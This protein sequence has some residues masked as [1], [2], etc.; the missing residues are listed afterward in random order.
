MLT[1]SPFHQIYPRVSI[2]H[3]A[4]PPHLDLPRQRFLDWDCHLL[5]CF[6]L[7]ILLPESLPS[8]LIFSQENNLALVRVLDS[9][10]RSPLYLHKDILNTLMREK[11]AVLRTLPILHLFQTTHGPFTLFQLLIKDRV[12]AAFAHVPT[13]SIVAVIFLVHAYPLKLL[14]AG[15]N[16]RNETF[17]LV[18]LLLLFHGRKSRE[19]HLSSSHLCIFG[20]GEHTLHPAGH[21]AN[22]LVL[23]LGVWHARRWTSAG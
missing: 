15:P 9:I 11:W 10:Q 14:G 16:A 1:M 23:R 13:M 22:W 4:T 7:P 5:L 2:I 19:C 18:V 17:G 3:Q 6:P 8:F 21:S 20:H 12:R